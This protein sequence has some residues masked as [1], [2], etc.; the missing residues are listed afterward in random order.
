MRYLELKIPPLI[1]LA[2]AASLMWAIAR[3]TPHWVLLYPGRPFVSAALLVLGVAIML[4]GV[5]AFRR[6]STTVDP[7]SPESTSRI[8]R[9]GIYRFTRNPMYL[10]MLVTLIAWLGWL[11]N[12]GAALVPALYGL[13]IT[14]W[15]IVPEERA[16]TEKFGAEYEAYRN[17]VRRWL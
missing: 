4:L 1:V 12:V 5:L 3:T 13:Y 6:A 17:S 2:I 8:V 10:G 16:L 14:R 9:S 7:R 11:S 15:Q